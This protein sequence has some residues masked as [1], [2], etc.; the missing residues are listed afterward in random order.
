MPIMFITVADSLA[1]R[2]AGFEV[3]ADDHLVKPF[4][5]RELWPAC[6]RSCGG[7]GPSSRAASTWAI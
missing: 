3:G 6:G 1:D 4:E 7:R 2:L 5:F